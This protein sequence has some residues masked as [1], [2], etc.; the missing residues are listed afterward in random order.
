MAKEAAIQQE[1][2]ALKKSMQSGSGSPKTKATNNTGTKSS[3][4]AA[5]K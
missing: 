1:K 3:K 4:P 2:A 5:R